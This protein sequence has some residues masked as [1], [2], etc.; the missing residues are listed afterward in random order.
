[1]VISVSLGWGVFCG[2]FGLC[3]PI[4]GIFWI[5][6]AP[7]AWS[8]QPRVRWGAI[9]AFLRLSR[10]SLCGHLLFAEKPEMAEASVVLVQVF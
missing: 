10:P 5:R 9:L 8:V 7:L 1:M 6:R 2:L 4:A 3:G